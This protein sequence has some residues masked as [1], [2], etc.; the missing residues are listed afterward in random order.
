LAGEQLDV[1]AGK[2]REAVRLQEIKDALSK[3]IGN[4]ADVIAKV[5]TMPKVNAFVSVLAIILRKSR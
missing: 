4:N 5:E 2:W 1:G 3:E